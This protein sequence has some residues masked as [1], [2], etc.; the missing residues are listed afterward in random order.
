MTQQDHDQRFKDLFQRYLR[1][2]MELFFPE[3]AKENGARLVTASGA[4]FVDLGIVTV[5]E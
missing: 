2:F 5:I 1:E 3:L 4:D